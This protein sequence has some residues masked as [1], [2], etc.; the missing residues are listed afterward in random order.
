MTSLRDKPQVEP[1]RDRERDA[2]ERL[3]TF[4][5]LTPVIG[6]LPSIWAL[7]RRQRDRRQLAACRLSIL[8]AAIWLSVYLSL[9]VGADLAGTSTALAFRLL[10]TNGLATSSYFIASVWLMM[11]LWQNKSV[12]LPGFSALAERMVV[13]DTA[14]RDN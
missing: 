8:L 5:Y 6:V 1:G 13:E 14:S 3:E 4:L 11:L 2:L 9:N 10:F 12:R 7:Y